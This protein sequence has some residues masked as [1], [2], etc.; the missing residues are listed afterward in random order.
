MQSPSP[1]IIILT[2]PSGS[3]KTTLA[4]YLL[5]KYPELDFSV[6]A[7]TRA[8]RQHEANGINYYFY[9]EN[10]FQQLITEG[11]LLEYQEVYPG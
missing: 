3:G 6:S 9:N 2:A 8:P 5:A 7:T 10:E 1:K 4:Q 11:K